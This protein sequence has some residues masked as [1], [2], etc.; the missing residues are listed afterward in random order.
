MILNKILAQLATWLLITTLSNSVVATESVTN[1]HKNIR[2]G[3]AVS[4][5][6][7]ASHVDGNFGF[8]VSTQTNTVAHYQQKIISDNKMF[9]E[10]K[11]RRRE[12]QKKQLEDYKL[13]VQKRRQQ[14]AR[15]NLEAS[16]NVSKELQRRQKEYIKY[17]EERRNLVNKMM[18][19]RRR[20]AEERRRATLLQ[21]HQTSTT[22]VT[23]DSERANVA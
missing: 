6:D 20:A 14:S 22:P 3:N 2:T 16:S 11:Q 12:M 1:E 23:I 10:M 19:E 13:F 15:N 5:A 4:D 21:M 7:I 17:M 8:T 18:D 9:Q